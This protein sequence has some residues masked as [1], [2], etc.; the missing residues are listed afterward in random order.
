M[1][2]DHFGRERLLPKESRSG[3]AQVQEGTREL[4]ALQRDSGAPGKEA[5]TRGTKIRT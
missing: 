1:A 5:N 3:Q 4:P 2:K